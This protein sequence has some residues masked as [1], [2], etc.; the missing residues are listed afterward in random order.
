MN[1]TQEAK[2]LILAGYTAREIQNEINCST[3][4]VYEIAKQHSL[5]ITKPAEKKAERIRELRRQGETL[6]EIAKALGMSK[7]GVSDI[8]RRYDIPQRKEERRRCAVCGTEFIVKDINQKYCS[9]QCGRKVWRGEKPDADDSRVAEMVA[10]YAPD[11][12][13]IGGYTGSDGSM[14]V[15]HKCG[16]TTRKS[17]V[18]FRHI[19]RTVK[20]DLCEDQE[21]KKLAKQRERQRKN[22]KDAEL[23]YKPVKKYKQ[24]QMK[25]CPVCG[26]FYVGW[27]KQCGNECR[28]EARNHYDSMKKRKRQEKAWTQE[29]KTISLQKLYERDHGVCWIC[30]GA[31]NYN[32]EANDNDYPSI[33]HVVPIA[34][35]GLD[36]WDNIRLAHRICNSAR[37]VKRITR[38]AAM[39]IAPR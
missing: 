19:K 38:P 10:K 14:V 39:S 18:T 24:I 5:K 22:K 15:R 12:E 20:C 34:H 9:V 37:G 21:R 6:G 26:C 7:C 25:E 36:E 13:Y 32:A 35:G 2:R 1:I 16:F 3:D 17:C 11:W 30:G 33:D 31:C 29:S 28:K 4:R 8:I 27:T 23:F